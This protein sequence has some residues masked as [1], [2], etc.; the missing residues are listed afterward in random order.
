MFLRPGEIIDF[1]K[2]KKYLHQGLTGA[3]FGCG[4]GYFTVLLA[5][6][7]GIN[8]IIYALDIDEEALNSA[9]ELA[10]NFRIKNIRFLRQ[11][12]EKTS[13]LNSNSLDFVFASQI[14]YQS[15]KPELILKEA[16]RIL[17]NNGNLII[18]EPT[19]INP[20]FSGQNIHS[21]QKIE[22]ICE[23]I[24]FKII[25]KKDWDNYHLW[26]YQK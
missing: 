19:I 26:I 8:G 7:I 15:E 5:N 4:S 12:L 17:K 20:L 25:E 11:D 16:F 13:G 14:L 18:L 6:T 24:G 23:Q 9:R 10:E 22:E 21:P 3:D 2:E 1:L